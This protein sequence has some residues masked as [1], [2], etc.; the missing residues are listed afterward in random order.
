[1]KSLVKYISEA[2][3]TP[4]KKKP[5]PYYIVYKI[6][7]KPGSLKMTRED[8]YPEAQSKYHGTSIVK[9]GRKE[10]CQK[11]IEAEKVRAAY[12]KIQNLNK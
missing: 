7:D 5:D 12:A 10:E 1:M 8:K 3:Q 9:R 11:F 2:T 6:M 4:P